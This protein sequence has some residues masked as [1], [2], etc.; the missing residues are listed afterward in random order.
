MIEMNTY[1]P[2]Q[3]VKNAE[4]VLNPPSESYNFEEES[5]PYFSRNKLIKK[6]QFFGQLEKVVYNSDN[7]PKAIRRKN[8]CMIL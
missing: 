4:A 1:E 7:N 3:C 6:C 2:G 5:P 8:K